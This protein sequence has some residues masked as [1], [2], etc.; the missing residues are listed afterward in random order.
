M[1]MYLIR[2]K[3]F[4]VCF[5]SLLTKSQLLTVWKYFS[6]FLY[7]ILLSGKSQVFF[8]NTKESSF[9]I[10]SLSVSVL[11]MKE[12]IFNLVVQFLGM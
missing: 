6:Y 11:N 1:L 7:M 5:R 12:Q 9:K 10:F 8:F 4:F 3:Y 2:Y